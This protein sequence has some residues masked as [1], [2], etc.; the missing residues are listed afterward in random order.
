[1]TQKPKILVFAH[2]QYLNG[3]SH[4][5][6]TVLEGLK[7]IYEFRVIVP[8]YGMM[9]DE[10][11][12]I[13]IQ[14]Q[15]INL[16]RCGYFNWVSSFDHLKKTI[17][18]LK[19]KPKY[20]KQLLFIAKEFIP[21]IVY[22]NTSVISFGNDLSIKINKPH[23]WHIRE[24][25]DID[26]KIQYLPSKNII[27]K[28]IKKSHTAIFTTY[29]LKKHWFG[30]NANANANAYNANVIY[31]GVLESKTNNLREIKNKRIILI[32]V[33]GMILNIKGQEFALKVFNEC[34]KNNST[35]RLHFYGDIANDEFYQELKNYVQLNQL[36]DVVHF[37]GYVRNNIIYE[38]IDVLMSC[39]TNEAF[40]RTL[41][42]AMSENIPVLAR[43]V[44]GP[45]E[46]LRENDYFSLYNNQEEAICKLNKLI[47]NSD[48]YFESAK[49]G[50]NLA[51]TNFSRQ[52]YLNNM[53]QIFK[54]ALNG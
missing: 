12:K 47:V 14:Y 18:Y 29:L 17:R 51:K 2:E 1:M 24:Y 26:F 11:I 54:K 46:I 3:A 16:P 40:G 10:L 28:K 6:L 20:D 32:G 19:N 15:I 50:Y 37:L 34:Y 22:T 5:L 41:I 33:V 7:S 13:D 44:G 31:N 8:D 45:S 52:S 36:T 53:D 49:K 25:G 48:F 39:S 27:I 38:E 4:S 21:D 35:I 30:T 42:E 43:N 23:I 9:V